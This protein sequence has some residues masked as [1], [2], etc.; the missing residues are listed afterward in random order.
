MLPDRF[1]PRVWLRDWLTKSTPAEQARWDAINKF[2]ELVINSIAGGTAADSASAD[3]S[4]PTEDGELPL[5]AP[6]RTSH[7]RSPERQ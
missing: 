5:S 3:E 2:S 6:L 7:P 4:R 1:N